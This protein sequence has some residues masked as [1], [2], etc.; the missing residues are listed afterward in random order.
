MRSWRIEVL[1]VPPGARVKSHM[2][3]VECKKTSKVANLRIHVERAINRIKT[4]RILKST[5]PI[6][7][8]A[9]IDDIIR[10]CAALCNIKPQ[11]IS[12]KKKVKKYLKV[13][14]CSICVHFAHFLF[15]FQEIL[16]LL[17]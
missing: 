10:T 16:K 12:T 2:T 1:V 7:M 8:S 11:L 3:S 4:Y 15:H 5:L 9:H 14:H 17:T 6:T 13:F